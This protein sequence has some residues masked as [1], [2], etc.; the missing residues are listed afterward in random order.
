MGIVNNKEQNMTAQD[1]IRE[2]KN[3]GF[4]NDDLNAMSQAI[5]FAR[6]QLAHEI[7]REIHPGLT[8]YFKD[9]SGSRIVGTVESV[10]IK[11]AV[12]RTNGLRY[13]VPCN[14]LEV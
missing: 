2:I 14:M 8:V 4:T 1:I 5:Q 13:R 11:N 6:R 10:K 3:G 9:R 12:V 7:K